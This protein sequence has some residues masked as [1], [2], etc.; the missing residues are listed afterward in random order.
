MDSTVTLV[1]PSELVFDRDS[2]LNAELRFR[3][4][5]AVVYSIKTG[6]SMRTEVVKHEYDADK[7]GSAYTATQPTRSATVVCIERNEIR[8]DTISFR[9]HEPVKISK[10]LKKH[11]FTVS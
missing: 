9:G 8:S 7:P 3:D 1:S 6:K 4:G 11:S 5:D 2:L 10:W